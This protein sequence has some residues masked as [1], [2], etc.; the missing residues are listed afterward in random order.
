MS[1][2]T[3]A[4]QAAWQ[5]EIAKI[6]NVLLAAEA[7]VTLER[8]IAALENQTALEGGGIASYSIAGRTVTRTSADIG[9]RMVN[10]LKSEL[11]R[12]CYGSV[13]LVNMDQSWGS[14]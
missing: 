4:L 13:T 12:L 9:K 10:E 11:W 2:A 8:Y 5:T 3:T 6:A 14:L 7:A 1:A